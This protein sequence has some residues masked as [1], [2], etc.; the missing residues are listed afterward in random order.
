MLLEVRN[1]T[2]RY[3]NRNVLENVSVDI[4]SGEGLCLLGPN[5]VGKTTL[6][7]SILG[8]LNVYSGGVYIDGEPINR[9]SNKQ[10]AHA[11]AYVPQAH[12]PPFAFSVL[13]VVIMGR[14]AH[15]NTFSTPSKKDRHLAI[16]A[17]EMLDVGFLRKR[18]YTEI[19]GG[20]R[21]MVL[22]ARAI[23][24]KPAFIVMDEPTAN[25]DFGNQVRVLKQI[26]QLRQ[27]GLGIVISTHDPDHAFAFATKVA[28]L[29][30]EHGLLIGA[31]DN[32][33]TEENMRN[34][35]GVEVVVMSQHKESYGEVK[36]CAPVV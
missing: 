13:D 19:S 23:A 2:F 18:L 11:I 34:A 25:L 22:I 29:T 10:I 5:G 30:N 28:L 24:Q 20:E 12:T 32:I 3:G 35:Y 21:Q 27:S 33:I 9:W 7:K 14:N 8:F 1:I 26:N 6:F 16:E 31:P 15:L 4:A 36:I 17:L